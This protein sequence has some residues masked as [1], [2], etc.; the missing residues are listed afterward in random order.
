[1]GMMASALRQGFSDPTLTDA[2]GTS[3]WTTDGDAFVGVQS[4][5]YWTATEWIGP[6]DAWLVNLF[7]GAFSHA[8][9]LSDLLVWPVRDGQ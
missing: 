9:K 3:G 8:S 1:M 7:G 6:T 5:S 4:T 2:R